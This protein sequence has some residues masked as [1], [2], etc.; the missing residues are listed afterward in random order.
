MAWMVRTKLKRLG[1]A[2]KAS[3][4]KQTVGASWVC[5]LSTRVRQRLRG[6]YP[7]LRTCLSFATSGAAHITPTVDFKRCSVAL[8]S[9]KVCSSSR[10]AATD[11]REPLTFCTSCCKEVSFPLVC[12]TT[13][14]KS[15]CWPQMTSWRSSKLLHSS[16]KISSTCLL[17]VFTF[18]CTMVITLL[19]VSCTATAFS[20]SPTWSATV[21]K[22]PRMYLVFRCSRASLTPQSL[23]CSMKIPDV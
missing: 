16:R 7:A 19:A 6:S 3:P 22:T 2:H 23:S 9:S 1:A 12:R 18:S 17:M 5:S 4:A 21:E 13:S 15:L 11:C 10:C 14:V 8:R 20:E